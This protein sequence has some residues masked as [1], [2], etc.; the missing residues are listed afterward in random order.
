MKFYI[1]K[2]IDGRLRISTPSLFTSKQGFCIEDRIKS[3]KGVISVRANSINSSVCIDYEQ[4]TLS[5]LKEKIRDVLKKPIEEIEDYNR[6]KEIHIIKKFEKKILGLLFGRYVLRFIL[7]MPYRKVYIMFRALS[8]IKKALI[9]IKSKRIKVELLDAV[10]IIISILQKNYSTASMMMFLLNLSDLL[11]EYTKSRGK[12]ELSNSIK[13]SVEKVLVEKDNKQEWISSKELN[14][15]DIVVINKGSIIPVDGVVVDGIGTVDES[16]MTGEFVPKVKEKGK[17]VFAGTV[18]S[19]GFLKIKVKKLLDQTRISKIVDAIENAAE[20]KSKLES[21]ASSIAD[22]IVPFSFILSGLVYLFTKDIQK[23][24][25]VLLVDY[26]C[27][28]KLTTPLSVISAL[29]DASNKD[30]LIKGGRYLEEMAQVD[31]FVFDKTGTLTTS[32][33]QVKHVISFDPYT[34][35]EFLRMAACIEEHFPHSMGYAIVQYAKEKN[36]NHPERHAEVEYIVAHGIKTKYDNKEVSIGSYRFIFEVNNTEITKEQ[37]EMV[38]KYSKDY[39]TIYMSVSNKLAGFICLFDPPRKESYKLIK[40]LK[41]SGI[42][43][44]YMLTG[45]GENI[46]KNVSNMLNIDGYK[47]EVLPDDKSPY[48]A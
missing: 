6:Q 34:K 33:P 26:S 10:A 41:S 8:F 31:T 36:I 25:S 11:E 40:D 44:V 48:V 12:L 21:K 20:S 9:S 32:N 28:L 7:T 39:S 24:T 22:N 14:I 13:I 1:K 42:K 23:M 30:I 5:N 19:E 16:K 18:L 47:A 46:A 35:E 27:G 29:K 17:F 3:I 4:I 2:S 37:E 15:D 45:D 43:K 38:K